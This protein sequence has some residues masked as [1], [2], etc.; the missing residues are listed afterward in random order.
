MAVALSL[1]AACGPRAMPARVPVVVVERG[2]ESATPATVE[3]EAPPAD[4]APESS[5]TVAVTYP[6]PRTVRDGAVAAAVGPVASLV[7]YCVAYADG[8]PP[9][10]AFNEH[11]VVESDCAVFPGPTS[12]E[13]LLP[14]APLPA[15]GSGY[16]EVRLVRVRAPYDDD[17]GPETSW[18]EFEEIRVAVVTDRGTFVEERGVARAN[19]LPASAVAVRRAIVEDVVPG[20][21]PELRIVLERF[22]GADDGVPEQYQSIEFVCG[23]GASGGLSC[24]RFAS[25]FTRGEVPRAPARASALRELVF[26]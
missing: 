21:A 11:I 17:E 5:P 6:A 1:A 8:A 26:P 2:A 3:V 16:R 19:W 7:H 13:G 23:F 20:G 24:A 15:P 12:D 10:R 25:K 22:V 9:E 18:D 4:E 14:A